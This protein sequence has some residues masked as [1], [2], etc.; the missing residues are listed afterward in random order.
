MQQV[1]FVYPLDRKVPSSNMGS[2][3]DP[4]DRLNDRMHRTARRQNSEVAIYRIVVTV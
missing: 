3:I 4:R 2:R 1:T